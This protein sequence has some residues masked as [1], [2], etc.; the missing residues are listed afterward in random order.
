MIYLT[1]FVECGELANRIGPESHAN[2]AV[3]SSPHPT[4]YKQNL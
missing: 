4:G 1:C 3:Y 2:D